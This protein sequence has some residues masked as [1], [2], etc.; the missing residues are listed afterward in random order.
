LRGDADREPPE[1]PEP[2]PS[3]RPSPRRLPRAV[4]TQVTTL[5]QTIYAGFND[6]HLTEKLRERHH[7]TVS[8]ESV[9]GGGCV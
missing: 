6:T 2:Y 3:A 4:Q 9:R 1:P 8:R 7:L 5:M